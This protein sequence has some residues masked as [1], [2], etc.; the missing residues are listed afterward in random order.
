M[1]SSFTNSFLD[2]VSIA[3][4]GAMERRNRFCFRYAFHAA[5]YSLWCERN[6]VKHGERLNPVIVLKKLVDKGYKATTGADFVTKELQ[7][8]DKLVTLQVRGSRVL[9]LSSTEALIV[10]PLFMMYNIAKSFESLDNWHQEFLKQASPSD[11]NKFPFIVLGNKVDIDG[12]R[13]RVVSEKK[14]DDWCAS[15]GNIPYS[16]TSAK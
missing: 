13:S 5:M 12:G 4:A 11:P 16:K 15:N 2:I 1:G 14:A 6:R 9:V 7:I 3:T 10:V 8:G